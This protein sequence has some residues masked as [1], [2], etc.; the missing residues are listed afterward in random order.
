[1]SANNRQDNN[2]QPASSSEKFC[3][4]II[5][6]PSSEDFRNNFSAIL[7]DKTTFIKENIMMKLSRNQQFHGKPNDSTPMKTIGD[8]FNLGYTQTKG[9]RADTQGTTEKSELYSEITKRIKNQSVDYKIRKYN[10]SVK[11]DSPREGQNQKTTSSSIEK[12]NLLYGKYK[13]KLAKAKF[14]CDQAKLEREFKEVEGCT[15][16][17]EIRDMKSERKEYGEVYERNK[18]WINKKQAWVDKEK[19]TLTQKN[20][21]NYTFKPTINKNKVLYPEMDEKQQAFTLKYKERMI[22]VEKLKQHVNNKLMP[23]YTKSYDQNHHFQKNL[24]QYLEKISCS[25]S[26]SGMQSNMATQA[27]FG[28]TELD[29]VILILSCE[30]RNANIDVEI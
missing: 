2:S 28:A 23:D 6:N 12:A 16:I 17:P 22:E 24:D 15:F 9:N 29:K 25:T 20:N 7:E 4:Q 5:D 14:K 19:T 10:P 13:E 27:L 1:M 21:N 3:E 11:K 18:N 26:Q 30:L 8:N